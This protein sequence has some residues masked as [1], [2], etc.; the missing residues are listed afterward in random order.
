MSNFDFIPN[1]TER[2]TADMNVVA[3]FLKAFMDEGRYVNS[4]WAQCDYHL[5]A[6]GTFVNGRNPDLRNEVRFKDC[7]VRYAFKV[8]KEKGY[9]ISIWTS[10]RGI[11]T[12][13][14]LHKTRDS[15]CRYI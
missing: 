4:G 12:E 11:S 2:N 14:N 10:E 5:L 1:N 3:L 9:H 7:D 15:R 6:D 13:Y 8:L